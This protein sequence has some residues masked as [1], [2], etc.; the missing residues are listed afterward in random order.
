MA[1]LFLVTETL[2]ILMHCDSTSCILV[3]GSK[4][5]VSLNI[6]YYMEVEVVG[7]IFYLFAFK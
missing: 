2:R 1:V 4:E 5:T 7:L 3:E 6:S